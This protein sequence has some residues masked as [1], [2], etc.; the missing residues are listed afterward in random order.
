MI[1][2]ENLSFSYGSTV[3]FRN[4]SFSVPAQPPVLLLAPSGFGKT[5][6]LRLLCGLET[7]SAGKITVPAPLSVVFQE[8][9][10]IPTLT[11]R[12]NLALVLPQGQPVPEEPLAALE[13]ADLLDRFPHQLSGGQKRRFAIARALLAPAEAFLMDEPFKGLDPELKARTAALICRVCRKKPLLVISHDQA[14]AAL[15]G[16]ET[17]LLSSLS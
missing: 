13:I 16:A 5:T 6:L 1:S 3:V 17:V 14:D 8:D 7:P 11:C 4:F 10:L 2:V 12:K 9:R 15:L